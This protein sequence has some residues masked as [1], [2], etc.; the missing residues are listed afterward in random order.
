MFLQACVCP[1]GGGEYLTRYTPQDQVHHPGPGAPLGP[2]T[3]PM[4][5]TPPSGTR[6]TPLQV[7]PPRDQVHPPPPGPG[8]PPGTRYTPPGDTATAADVTHPTGM[9]SCSAYN[10]I[11]IFLKATKVNFVTFQLKCTLCV[12]CSILV[13]WQSNTGR[14]L[15]EFK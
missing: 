14:V 9:H 1:H 15:V 10:W 13:I 6:Y 4:A 5:G 2:G 12:L 8:T 7:Q 11:F 3:P